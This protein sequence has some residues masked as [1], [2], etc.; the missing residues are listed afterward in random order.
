MFN[1][2]PASS[3]QED[4]A[5]YLVALQEHVLAWLDGIDE[6]DRKIEGNK[7]FLRYL[8]EFMESGNSYTDMCELYQQVY[9]AILENE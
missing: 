1:N 5:S 8:R 6:E 3:S 9:L 2:R 4:Q 7:K